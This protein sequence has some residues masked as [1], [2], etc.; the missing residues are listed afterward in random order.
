MH[1]LK[2]ETGFTLQLGHSNTQHTAT[3]GTRVYGQCHTEY[4]I[5]LARNYLTVSIFESHSQYTAY[6]LTDT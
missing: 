6:T 4:K 5:A 2:H 1:K 3:A